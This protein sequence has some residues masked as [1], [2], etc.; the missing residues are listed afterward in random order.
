MEERE[1]IYR[2]KHGDSEELDKLV[3]RYYD[4]IYHFLCR[5]IG[6]DVSAQDVTQEVFLKFVRALPVYRPDGKLRAFLFTIAVNC[7]N[8]FFRS[9]RKTFSLQDV[10]ER[11]SPEESPEDSAERDSARENVRKAVSALPV[12]QRDVIILRYFHDMSLKEISAV[13]GV[14]VATVKTRLHRG[15]KE[16]EKTLKGED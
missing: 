8:D 16:L 1:Q 14:P 12:Y 15:T 9:S 6:N 2:I 7:S 5:R 10:A 3:R 11:E 4:E 13:V